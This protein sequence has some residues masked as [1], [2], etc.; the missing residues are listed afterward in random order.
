MQPG[1]GGCNLDQVSKEILRGDF[2]PGKTALN[3]TRLQPSGLHLLTGLADP[4]R[5]ESLGR[6]ELLALVDAMAKS[7][8]VVILDT[9]QTLVLEAT[10]AALD[11]AD[12]VII[13]VALAENQV[14]HLGRYLTLLEQGLRLDKQKIRV[15]VNH[16]AGG[17]T[18]PVVTIEEVL[19]RPV[20]GEVPYYRDWAAWT[21]E[22]LPPVDR[23]GEL[24][25]GLVSVPVQGPG[26]GE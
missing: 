18:L 10:L 11:A 1:P 2:N 24:L 7:Y 6:S 12:L 21:G 16:V 5:A 19:G 20:A 14:R 23:R 22:N 25:L 13:H 9:N 3:L 26:K 8:E 4:V 17:A 15:V